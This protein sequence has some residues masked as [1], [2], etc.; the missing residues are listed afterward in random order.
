[1]VRAQYKPFGTSKPLFTITQLSEFTL[2]DAVR[3][4]FYTCLIIKKGTGINISDTTNYHFNAVQMYCYTPF[5]LFDFKADGDF[6]GL[7]LEFH[8]DFF[9]LEKHGKELQCNGVL[10][11]DNYGLPFFNLNEQE[12]VSLESA[13]TSMENEIIRG[14]IAL[15]EALI[16]YLK[17]FLVT[18]VRVKLKA[19]Q[20][21]DSGIAK[22][23]LISDFENMVELNYK[24]IH[25][26]GE[27]AQLLGTSL[28]TL[29][30]HFARIHKKTAIQLIQD[31]LIIE[32]KRELYLTQTGIKE[33]AFML[34]FN[35]VQ[36]FTRLFKKK[37][38]LTPGEYRS[39]LGLFR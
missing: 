13:I 12:L 18:A 10:F 14:E 23:K 37:T 22:S 20:N 3:N 17:L 24:S 27:Y 34:G 29:N 15:G 25:S 2:E 8:S 26:P 7:I 1:M 16:S 9:C 32:A 31:R 19:N 11:N 33:I 21:I 5:Q 36:Y 6:E 38:S 35:D 4:E 28:K 39:R 30:N